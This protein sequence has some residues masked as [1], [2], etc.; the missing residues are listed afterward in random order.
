MSYYYH[1]S[2][3]EKATGILVNGLKQSGGGVFLTESLQG[4][5]AFANLYVKAEGHEKTD[6]FVF[7]IDKEK[8]D[9]SKISVSNDHNRKFLPVDAYVY[10]GDIHR[11]LVSVEEAYTLPQ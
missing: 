3:G 6:I 4:A 10:F 9:Q 11:D 8:L 2:T 7:K 5:L 1:Y